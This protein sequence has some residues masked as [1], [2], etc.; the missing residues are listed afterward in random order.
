LGEFGQKSEECPSGMGCCER[1]MRMDWDCHR[2]RRYCTSFGRR[3][4][5]GTQMTAGRS[6]IKRRGSTDLSQLPPAL[7]WASGD[8]GFLLRWI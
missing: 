8:S 1:I 2:G 6:L 7:V 3:L 4:L 5:K